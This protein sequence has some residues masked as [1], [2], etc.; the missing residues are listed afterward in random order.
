MFHGLLNVFCLDEN[1]LPRDNR[2]EG[3]GEKLATRPSDWFANPAVANWLHHSRLRCP[4]SSQGLRCAT[5]QGQNVE[6]VFYR[7]PLKEAQIKKRQ[8]S[9]F[10]RF[11]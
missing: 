11:R 5:C 9:D 7:L 6:Q 8:K 4:A 10:R 3:L 2:K 1:S